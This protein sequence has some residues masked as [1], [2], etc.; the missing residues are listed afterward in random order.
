MSRADR[1]KV[2][3][4]ARLNQIRDE[5]RKAYP[6][7]AMLRQIV[8]QK[9][10]EGKEDIQEFDHRMH[11]Y[12]ALSRI[13][14]SITDE[15]ASDGNYELE[16]FEGINE[17]EQ[18]EQVSKDSVPVEP[19]QPKLRPQMVKKVTDKIL[20]SFENNQEELCKDLDKMAVHDEKGSIFAHSYMD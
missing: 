17:S 15:C 19:I 11:G 12:T 9:G 6:E 4:L 20:E 13:D 3:Y 10:E 1:E 8:S 14:E 5:L 7:E 16:E 2:M 18:S